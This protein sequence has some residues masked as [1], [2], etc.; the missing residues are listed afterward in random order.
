[1]PATPDPKIGLFIVGA[2]KAGTDSVRHWLNRCP[3]VHVHGPVEPNHFCT[4]ALYVPKDSAAWI[5][6]ILKDGQGNRV[7]G[8]KSTWYLCSPAAVENI[9]AYNPEARILLLHRD[10]AG[11]VRSLH[12]E[13]LK[14]GAEDERDLGRAWA[15]ALGDPGRVLFEN[16]RVP[17][18]PRSCRIGEH[19]ARWIARFGHAQVLLMS[20]GD[21]ETPE[22][23]ARLAR[24]LSLDSYP[25]SGAAMLNQALETD[26][27]SAPARGLRGWLLARVRRLRRA[28]R[29]DPAPL[30]RK[31]IPGQVPTTADPAAVAGMIGAYFAEDAALLAALCRDNRAAQDRDA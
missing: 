23:R 19:A 2:P 6:R 18:Y 15:A 14:L 24:F 8:E 17:D 5:R 10:H 3:G 16:T 27:P 13:L 20:I 11:L 21:L 28:L 25:D 9:H 30:P 7:I 26:R 29:G 1:M 22:G 12:G 31:G 4:D